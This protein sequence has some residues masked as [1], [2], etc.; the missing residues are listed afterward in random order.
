MSMVFLICLKTNHVH[1]HGSEYS[2]EYF[3]NESALNQSQSQNR[4][5]KLLVFQ[6]VIINEWIS[7]MELG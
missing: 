2:L 6:C 4:G 5:L 1:I 3:L 7:L